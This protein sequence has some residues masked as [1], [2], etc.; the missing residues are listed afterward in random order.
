MQERASSARQTKRWSV[1]KVRP[2][3]LTRRCT[4]NHEETRRRN[5]RFRRLEPIRGRLPPADCQN[6]KRRLFRRF[7]RKTFGDIDLLQIWGVLAHAN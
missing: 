3:G 1:W 6:G 5:R 2:A 4:K 7:A